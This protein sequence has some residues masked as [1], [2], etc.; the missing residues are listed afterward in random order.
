VPGVVAPFIQSFL[1]SENFY[2][3]SLEKPWGRTRIAHSAKIAICLARE[4]FKANPASLPDEAQTR[5]PPAGESVTFAF[6]TTR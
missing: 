5:P 6:E 1:A 2:K 3:I 4:L